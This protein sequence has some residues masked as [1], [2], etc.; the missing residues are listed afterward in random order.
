MKNITF[1]AKESLIQKAREKAAGENTS[2]NQK[3]REWLERYTSKKDPVKK[4]TD[5]MKKMDYARPGRKFSR[6]ELN[7]R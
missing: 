2:L 5:I 4:Y 1:S 3:F 7:E 6:N